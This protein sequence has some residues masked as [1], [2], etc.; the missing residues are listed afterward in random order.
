[1]RE[2]LIARREHGVPFPEGIDQELFDRIQE[3]DAWLWFTLYGKHDF[4]FN[5][6]HGG[7]SQIYSHLKQLQEVSHSQLQFSCIAT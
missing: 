4:C 3:Y 7:V 5:S 6:F 1:M 2:V